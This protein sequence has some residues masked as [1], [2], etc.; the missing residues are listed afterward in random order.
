MLDFLLD[1]K[2]LWEIEGEEFA[3][4]KKAMSLKNIVLSDSAIS[5]YLLPKSRRS[6]VGTC[7]HLQLQLISY[8]MITLI[9]HER[10]NLS[11]QCRSNATKMFPGLDMNLE[12]RKNEHVTTAGNAKRMRLSKDALTVKGNRW[13]KHLEKV[14]PY[15]NVN[16]ES[17][18]ET[19]ALY[20][21][22]EQTVSDYS[23]HSTVVS[24]FSGAHNL[25]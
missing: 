20:C 18:C 8:Q 13:K 9:G 15:I 22:E 16:L 24:T 1:I 10:S 6:K 3:L 25:N 23:W 5:L 21:Y 7:Y 11:V 2:Y 17:L 12:P 14:I 19:V 4:L